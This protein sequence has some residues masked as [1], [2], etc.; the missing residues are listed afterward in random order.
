MSDN[1]ENYKKLVF[2]AGVNKVGEIQVIE[3]LQKVLCNSIDN[4]NGKNF[5][6]DSLKANVKDDKVSI[7]YNT[8]KVMYS[9]SIA[10]YSGTMELTKIIGYKY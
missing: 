6:I 2:F 4:T 1:K 7:T 8:R 3:G 10:D 5:I 9:S